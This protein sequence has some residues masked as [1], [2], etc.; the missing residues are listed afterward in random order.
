MEARRTP[1]ASVWGAGVTLAVESAGA[2]GLAVVSGSE[3][4]KAFPGSEGPIAAGAVMRTGAAW[5]WADS[6]Q[7]LSAI[8]LSTRGRTLSEARTSK[9]SQSRRDLGRPRRKP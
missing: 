1:G 5:W 3:E 6:P 2:S 8:G 4:A 9:A 7:N